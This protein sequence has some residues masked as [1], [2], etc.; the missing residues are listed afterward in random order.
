MLVLLLITALFIAL[1][2]YFFFR[3]EKIQNTLRLLKRD[4]G[5]ILKEN[6]MLTESL[7]LITSN[8]EEVAKIRLQLL[9]DENNNQPYV[10]NVKLF[11]PLINNYAIIFNECLKEKGRLHGITKECF[12]NQNSSD[13]KSFINKI[14]KNDEKLQR[15]W[16]SNNFIGFISLVEALLIKYNTE[17]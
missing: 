9:L 7:A 1:S 10:D 5:K 8:H 12:D 15:L 4:K 16:E 17:K 3:A 14:I 6:T 2:I 11:Q 13:Y